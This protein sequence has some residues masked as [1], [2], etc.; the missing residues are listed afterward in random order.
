MNMFV[1]IRKENPAWYNTICLFS[2]TAFHYRFC[3]RAPQDQSTLDTDVDASCLLDGYAFRSWPAGYSL[4]VCGDQ[5][6]DTTLFRNHGW[7]PSDF[8]N[9]VIN[10]AMVLHNLPV[11]VFS[12]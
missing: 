3:F 5:E 10:E 11:D 6:F 8:V 4:G 9:V 12:G 1:E 2:P 7:L